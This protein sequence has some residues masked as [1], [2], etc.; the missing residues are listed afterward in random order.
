MA[1]LSSILQLVG[2]LQ[3]IPKDKDKKKSFVQCLLLWWK[4]MYYH[5]YFHVYISLLT[6]PHPADNSIISHSIFDYEI[7]GAPALWL[8][9]NTAPIVCYIIFILLTFRNTFSLCLSFHHNSKILYHFR[10]TFFSL[11]PQVFDFG[12]SQNSLLK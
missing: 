9:I 3:Y 6:H 4:D 11:S 1:S 8:R 10:M 7:Q 5:S 12:T 2:R